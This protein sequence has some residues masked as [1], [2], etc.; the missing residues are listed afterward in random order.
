MRSFNIRKYALANE[1]IYLNYEK[2][3]KPVASF[4]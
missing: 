1:V 2:L 4:R 3:N